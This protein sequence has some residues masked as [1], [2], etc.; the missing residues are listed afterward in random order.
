MLVQRVVA[1]VGLAALEPV[2]GDGARGVAPHVPFE[3]A[4]FETGSSLYSKE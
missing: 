1:D 3:K 2:D 4:D